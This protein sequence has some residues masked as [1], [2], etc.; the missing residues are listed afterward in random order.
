[1]VDIRVTSRYRSGL[2]TSRIIRGAQDQAGRMDRL[3]AAG[4]RFSHGRGWVERDT[5]DG[6]LE[7]TQ[8]IEWLPE[9]AGGAR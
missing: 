6:E 2:V 9:A 5:G 7:C 4:I 1:M 3:R 8:R